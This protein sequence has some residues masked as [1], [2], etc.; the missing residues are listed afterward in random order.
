MHTMEAQRFRLVVA[1]LGG[2]YRG[3]QRQNSVPSVQGEIEKA[4]FAAFHGL[5]VTVEGS[6]RTD[7][8]VHAIGQVAHIDLPIKISPPSLL[9]ALNYKLPDSIRIL[10]AAAVPHSFHSRKSSRGKRYVYRIRW[11]KTPVI[12]PWRML[13]TAR[14]RPPRNPD[15]I[16]QLVTLFGGRRDWAPF[17][18]AHPVTRTTVRTVFSATAV[19]KPF[20]L[21]LGFVGNGFL[22]YQVRRMVGA[23]LQVGWGQFDRAWLEQLLSSNRHTDDVYTA[24]AQGLTLD[25]VYFRTPLMRFAHGPKV[26]SVEMVDCPASDNDD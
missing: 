10:S 17:T 2:D 9:K 8:G 6:G 4:L 25:K 19:I 12:P 1:Y 22:R 14:I 5:R 18:V 15:E 13:R 11:D 16:S 23:L 7:A 24:P 3:W 21:Q 20:G 26:R